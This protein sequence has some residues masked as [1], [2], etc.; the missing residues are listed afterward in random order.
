[1]FKQHSDQLMHQFLQ[2]SKLIDKVELHD[3]ISRIWRFCHMNHLVKDIFCMFIF[4]LPLLSSWLSCCI[5]FVVSCFHFMPL[6][7]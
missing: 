5:S 7:V 6:T 2:F 4:L 3:S 1:M